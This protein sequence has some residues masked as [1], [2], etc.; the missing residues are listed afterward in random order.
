LKI[1]SRS[2][3]TPRIYVFFLAVFAKIVASALSGVGFVLKSTVFS[4]SGMI[5]WL[6]FFAFLIVV[7]IPSADEV[8]QKYMKWL[9]P[10]AMAVVVIFCIIGLA[11]LFIGVTIG[12]KSIGSDDPG[13]DLSR[14]MVSLDN[15]F[16]YNDATALTHQAAENLLDGK[17]PYAEANI[18]TAAQEFNIATDKLTPLREG[19]FVNVFPYPS[20]DQMNGIWQEAIQDPTHLPPELETKYNYPALSFIFLAPFIK[21]GIGDLRLVYLIIIFIVLA[22]VFFKIPAKYRLFFFAALVTSIEIWYSLVAG[23]TSFVYFPCLLLAWVFYRRH[24]W[25]SAVFMAIMVAT[26][27]IAWFLAPFYLIVI[28]RTMGWRKALG[29]LGVIVGIFGAANVWFFAQNPE[30][31]YSSIFAP[32]SGNLFPLGVGLISAVTSGAF[33]ITTPHLF[34]ALEFTIFAIVLVW[35]FFNCRRYPDMALVL[36]ILPLFFAWRSLWGYF[37]YIDI[38]ILASILVNDYGEKTENKLRLSPV[39]PTTA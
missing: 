31:W 10:A 19:R 39:L 27:Q 9:K 30:L 23:E 21:I 4:V 24:L 3:A 14:L 37:F 12:L 16:G 11:L 1:L 35:Y 28:Y 34:N 38:I 32:V 25:F 29:V 13:G 5:V 20:P 18:I 26:K 36:S 17:N 7:T 2:H 22:Y 6:S 33:T 15:V 8:L